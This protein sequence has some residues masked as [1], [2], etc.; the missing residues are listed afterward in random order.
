MP[1]GGRRRCLRRREKLRGLKQLQT[2]VVNASM[3]DPA[4]ELKHTDDVYRAVE[5][6][7][8]GQPVSG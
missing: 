7:V 6:E 2:E 1:T 4:C 5:I 3:A 8:S